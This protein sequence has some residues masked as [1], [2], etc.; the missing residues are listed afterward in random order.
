MKPLSFS[1]LSFSRL[2]SY[3]SLTGAVVLLLWG[4]IGA[5]SAQATNPWELLEDL[6]ASLMDAGPITGSFQQTYVPAGFSDGDVESGQLSLWLPKCLRWNYQEPQAKHFLLC[7][8]QVWFWNDLEEG[9]RHYSIQPEKEPGLDLLL[10]EVA[11]LKERYVAESSRLDDGT[12]QIRWATP[13]G[14]GE[15][16][17]ATI[18]I[19]PVS[20][21]VVGL[22]YTDGEGNLTRF[23]LGGYQTL[24]HTGL[25]QPPQDVEWIDE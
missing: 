25:F 5:R 18:K 1:P 17:H 19:D 14:A 10:V 12:F 20:D 21:R 6:R 7:E 13:E 8:D 15:P 2:R 16:F 3:T 11:K 23:K 24:A 22:E 4:S 9:G